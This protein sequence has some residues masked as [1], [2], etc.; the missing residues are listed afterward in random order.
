MGTPVQKLPEDLVES[1]ARKEQGN[2]LLEDR[3]AQVY[4]NPASHTF[5]IEY[6]DLIGEILHLELINT[7]GHTVRSLNFRNTGNTTLLTEG[8]TDGA[9]WLR[10]YNSSRLIYSGKIIILQ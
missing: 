8:L 9:Y 4:P 5:H 7:T 1:E 10:L 3:P 6:S 2:N